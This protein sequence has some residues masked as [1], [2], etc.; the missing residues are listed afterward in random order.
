M[1]LD[2]SVLTDDDLSG[3]IIVYILSVENKEQSDQN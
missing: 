1:L 2:L 3:V